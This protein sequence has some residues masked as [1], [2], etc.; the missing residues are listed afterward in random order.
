M[1]TDLQIAYKRHRGQGRGHFAALR[2]IGE[3]TGLD[4]DTVQRC[5][6]RAATADKVEA[7]RIS[8]GQAPKE[9]RPW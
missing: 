6:D 2:G 1:A 8:R 5:L 7:R 4:Q 3:E 9:R